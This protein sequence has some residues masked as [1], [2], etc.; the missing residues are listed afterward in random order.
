MQYKVS[1][2]AIFKHKG[3]KQ[4]AGG[5][6]GG[7]KSHIV[8]VG[9]RLSKAELHEIFD[10]GDIETCLRVVVSQHIAKQLALRT[11]AAL[12][13][14]AFAPGTGNKFWYDSGLAESH[15]LHWSIKTHKWMSTT[16]RAVV[17]TVFLIGTRLQAVAEANQAALAG[18]DG[19][20]EGVHVDAAVGGS[21]SNTA[22][23]VDGVGS[24]K[25]K[26]KSKNKGGNSNSGNSSNSIKGVGPPMLVWIPDEMW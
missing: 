17:K 9:Q 20:D 5:S 21:G 7:S 16:R 10:S 14:E 23:A 18:G 25:G 15:K 3:F 8:G 13:A 1:E 24:A 26:G 11:K 22:V 19:D 12:R 6:Y 4:K 2:K